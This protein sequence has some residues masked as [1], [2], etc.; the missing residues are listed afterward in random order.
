MTEKSSI[1]L[2]VDI[3]A[4]VYQ[5]TM[6]V[7]KTCWVFIKDGQ[8]VL[9]DNIIIFKNFCVKTCQFKTRPLILATV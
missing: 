7:C 1:Q 9:S 8:Q 6:H 3:R 4:Y 5:E 2:L